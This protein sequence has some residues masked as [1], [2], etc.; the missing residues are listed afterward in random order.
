VGADEAHLTDIESRVETL[1][2]LIIKHHDAIKNL[3]R[4]LEALSSNTEN[5]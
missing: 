2:R 1:E 5:E 4:A 3:V